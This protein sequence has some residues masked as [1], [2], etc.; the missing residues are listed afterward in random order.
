MSKQSGISSLLAAAASLVVIGFVAVGTAAPA[1]AQ[2]EEDLAAPAGS[3]VSALAAPEIYAAAVRD[4]QNQR[5]VF[6]GASE[7][8]AAVPQGSFTTAMIAPQNN[9]RDVRLARVGR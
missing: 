4:A 6:Y 9:A 3:F 5:V 8:D 1:Q 2:S 7:E